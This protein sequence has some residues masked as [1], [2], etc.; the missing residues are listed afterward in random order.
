M[1][2]RKL[3]LIS[4]VTLA[5]LVLIAVSAALLIFDPRTNGADALRTGGLAA[6]SIVALYALWLNDRRRRTG[7]QRQ[8]LE[9]RRTDLERD[10]V[11]DERFAR[12]VELLGHD[13][14]QV[15]VGAL[16]ALAG[17]ARNHSGYTQTVLDVLCSYLRRPFRHPRHAVAPRDEATP[18]NPVWTGQERDDAE[19]ELQV[20]L[21]AQR[22]IPDLLPF[23][24][25][26]AAPGYDLDLTNATL[27]YFDLSERRIGS[28]V[29]RY[30]RLYSSNNFSR[31]EFDGTAWFTGTKTAP[32]R[33][34][35]HFRCE[36]VVFGERAWFSGVDFHGR[37]SFDRT[38][39]HG[40][41]KFAHSRFGDT[42]SMVDAT[43][44]GV[45][46]FRS[47]AFESGVDLR[48]VRWS[49]E[50]L[51]A[52]VRTGSGGAALPEDWGANGEKPNEGKPGNRDQIDA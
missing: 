8:E 26:A 24:G 15:R 44:E 50:V 46:D 40:R 16:H 30:A 10:R 3:G 31:C 52:N 23:A 17:L 19:R 1:R 6:G 42:V 7:E 4:T 49:G 45:A 20:R 21:T 2:E 51:H 35:G 39:F 43:F 9:H 22:L 13:S 41:A 12:A 32:G 29:L 48:S 11:S 34:A 38:R 28:L 18:D 27:E 14:D 5:V 36:D 37:S 25:D 33:L 47:C